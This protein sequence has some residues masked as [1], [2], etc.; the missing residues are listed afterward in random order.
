[1]TAFDRGEPLTMG[2]DVLATGG[3]CGTVER[4]I[5]DP[6]AQAVTHLVVERINEPE[7]SRLVPVELV[8]SARG[9]QILLRCT[10][11]EFNKLEIA[12]E[13]QFLPA[14][15]TILG[16]GDHALRQPYYELLSRTGGAHHNKPIYSDRVPTGEVD[17]HRGDHVHATD[18]WI[19]SVEGLVIDPA[20]HHVTHVL[21]Q[22][23][24]LWGRKQVAIPIGAASRVGE[25]IRVALSKQ[26]VED[27]PPI[28]LK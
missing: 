3:A 19:G 2:A 13:E 11:A 26:E 6:V 4:V 10:L 1:M 17:V 15:E 9:D 5:V 20:D 12:K 25:A 14:T 8:E 27:L 16:Y 22:E 7:F 23:G 28:E 21:L 18:G 24:H